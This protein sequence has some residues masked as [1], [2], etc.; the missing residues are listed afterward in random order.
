MQGKPPKVL[1]RQLNSPALIQPTKRRAKTPKCFRGRWNSLPLLLLLLL[2]LITPNKKKTAQ[3]IRTLFLLPQ[4]FN[5]IF[6][7]SEPNRT[8]SYQVR[9]ELNRI[10][11]DIVIFCLLYVSLLNDCTVKVYAHVSFDIGRCCR[12]C[13]SNSQRSVEIPATIEGLG[14]K[15]LCHVHDPIFHRFGTASVFCKPSPV[16]PQ[17]M[18]MDHPYDA[19]LTRFLERSWAVY[20]FPY[21]KNNVSFE[22]IH[23]LSSIYPGQL[24]STVITNSLNCQW[25]CFCLAAWRVSSATHDPWKEWSPR[26]GDQRC[27][28]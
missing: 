3:N 26:C 15:L 16:L 19:T 21:K 1:K 7:H 17:G 14:I 10:L 13:R 24:M 28:K 18:D 5:P 25:N 6:K 8:G 27:D 12:K 23:N 2:L 9:T 4:E 20:K 11:P 22:S